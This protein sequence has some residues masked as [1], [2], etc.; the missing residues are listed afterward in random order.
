MAERRI[1]AAGNWKMNKTPSEAKA[2]VEGLKGLVADAKSEVV[3]GVPFVCIPAVVEAAKGS[4]IKVAAQNV[5]W[6]ANGAYT[7]EVS[8]AMLKELNVDYVIIGHSERR[9]YFGETDEM[10]NKK[11]RAI[12]DAGMIPIIC[13]GESLTQREQGVTAEHV[14]YQIKIA[15]LGLSAE[16]VSRLV[17]AYE[18]IWA[19]GTGKTATNEQAEEV[20]AIIRQL[21]AELY[22]NDVAEKTRILY[23][24]SVKASNAA[25]LFAM[26]NIDGGLVG[27]AS[28][29]LDEFEKIVKAG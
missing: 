3:V 29:K 6:E 17:I 9:E 27:G 20:C 22:G 28:L 8:C 21:I 5:H 13:C 25:E 2:F 12:L 14:R 10:V 18:P 19:I 7:G 15:L 1:M 4:N 11:A 24:G 26:P 23:G 16:E